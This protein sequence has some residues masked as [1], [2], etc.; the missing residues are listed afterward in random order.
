MPDLMS[1]LLIG[2]IL[3]ELFNIKKKSIVVM[4]ALAPD[5]LAKIH[6][7]YYYLGINPGIL[8][9]SFHTPL[10]LFLVSLL[11]APLFLY[12]SIKFLIAFNIGSVSEI[13]SDLTMKHFTISGSRLFF[14][15][16]MK[17]YTLNWIW[18]EQSIYVLVALLTVYFALSAIKKKSLKPK[19]FLR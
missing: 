17:N 4:G 3:A 14:P 10:M 8:F 7:V 13:L 19:F 16:S 15:F 12:D 9:S 18:P 11:L 2:L 5:L 6:L 1:H